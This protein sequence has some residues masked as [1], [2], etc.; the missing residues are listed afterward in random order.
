MT[1]NGIRLVT[2]IAVLSLVLSSC[3]TATAPT[4]YVND[5]IDL[6]TGLVAHYLLAGNAIDSSGNGFNGLNQGAAPTTDE[7]G[8]S[9]RAL[10][11]NGY[12]RY[13]L[14]GDI[15]DSVFTK[16]VASFTVTGWANTIQYGTR[17]G[18][19]GLMIGKAGGG[20]AGPYEWTVTHSDAKIYAYVFF[21]TLALNYEALAAPMGTGTWFHFA[22]VFDGT[23]PEFGRLQLYLNGLPVRNGERT[24]IGTIGTAPMNSSQNLTIG[25]GHAT[26]NPQV[27]NNCYNG[28]LSDIRIY[29]RA[30]TASKILAIYASY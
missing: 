25:A 30:L 12:S 6:T 28:S 13:V 19:G 14:C 26:R 23:Q 11:F 27:P 22:L 20:D 21:D 10:L 24:I 4:V 9:N 5:T 16:P 8:R 2:T 15:L 3:K 1:Y 17:S 7:F 18:G 29:N